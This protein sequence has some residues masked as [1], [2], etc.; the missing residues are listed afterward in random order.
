MGQKVLVFS[1]FIV[2]VEGFWF[3]VTAGHILRDIR[4]NLDLG[5]EFSRW[6]LAD[7]KAEQPGDGGAIPFDFNID[8]WLVV[9]DADRGIDFAAVP[10]APLFRLALQSGGVEAISRTAW[11]EPDPN[12]DFWVL[13]GFPSESIVKQSSAYVGGKVVFTPVTP[14]APPPLAGLKTENQ[15]Y[16]RLDLGAKNLVKDLDGMSGGPIF[17]VNDDGEVTHYWVIGVQSGVYG[18]CVAG[19]PFP[20]FG[21]ALGAAVRSALVLSPT[22]VK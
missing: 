4:V 16:Y 14:S 18:E 12:H 10:L 21:E 9:E 20:A 1:G 3:Y 11:S 13:V 6:R 5:N 2:E 17:A 22:L 15:F 7:Q 8:Q 19:C